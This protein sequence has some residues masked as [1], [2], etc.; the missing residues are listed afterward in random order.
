MVEQQKQANNYMCSMKSFIILNTHYMYFLLYSP[1]GFRYGQVK[2]TKKS[3]KCSCSTWHYLQ[4][5]QQR[6]TMQEKK[7]QKRLQFSILQFKSRILIFLLSKNKRTKERSERKQERR[8]ENGLGSSVG[9]SVRGR[10]S[11]LG[12]FHISLY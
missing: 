7:D 11:V 1:T 4:E 2:Q 10:K 3:K 5:W 12:L 8:G 9:R 6:I